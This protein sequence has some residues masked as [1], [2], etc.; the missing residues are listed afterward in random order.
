MCH[1]DKKFADSTSRKE[2]KGAQVWKRPEEKLEKVFA[3]CSELNDETRRG[4]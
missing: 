4:A 2:Q 1:A 3:S